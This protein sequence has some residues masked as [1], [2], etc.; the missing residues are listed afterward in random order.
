MWEV[1]WLEFGPR[2]LLRDCRG[3]GMRDPEPVVGDGAKGPRQALAEVLRAARSQRCWIRLAAH[4][5]NRHPQFKRR[6]VAKAVQEGD[7]GLTH[8]DQP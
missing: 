1:S 6:S 2:E 7:G 3:R 4:P 8:S 5:A